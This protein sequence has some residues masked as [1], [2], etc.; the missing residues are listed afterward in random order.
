MKR[1]C[2]AKNRANFDII[3]SFF[4]EDPC[5]D[6]ASRLIWSWQNSTEAVFLSNRKVQFWISVIWQVFSFR[7]TVKWE[8]YFSV[9]SSWEVHWIVMFQKDAV[10]KGPQIPI[11]LETKRHCDLRFGE[12]PRVH[13]YPPTRLPFSK[14]YAKKLTYTQI[15]V[16]WVATSKKKKKN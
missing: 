6:L 1:T 3:E 5:M 13:T 15:R 12:T 16:I 2:P 8:K 7:F 14:F 9:K 4:Q 11:K 10:C